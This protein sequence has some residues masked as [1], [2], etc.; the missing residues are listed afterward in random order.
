[1]KLASPTFL[2]PTI[3]RGIMGARGSDMRLWRWIARL[4]IHKIP[5]VAKR[6]GVKSASAAL[7]NAD[8][9]DADKLHSI[10]TAT[11]F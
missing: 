9:K 4:Y 6:R 7:R 11:G 1:M 2:P 5:A 10:S 8:A 3:T